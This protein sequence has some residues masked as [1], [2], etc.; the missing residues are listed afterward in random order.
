[1]NSLLNDI[2]SAINEKEYLDAVFLY[3][4]KPFDTSTEA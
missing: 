2:Y 4:S 1:M 3:L